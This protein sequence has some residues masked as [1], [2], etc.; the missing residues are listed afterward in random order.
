MQDPV[1]WFELQV[2]GTNH[3]DNTFRRDG[4]WTATAPSILAREWWIPERQCRQS[5][6]GHAF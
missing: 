4:G 3:D 5:L 2:S 1:Q 6:C